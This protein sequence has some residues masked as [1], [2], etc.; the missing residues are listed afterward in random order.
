MKI[1]TKIDLASPAAE[2]IA[3]LSDPARL[4]HVLQRLGVIV[5]PGVQGAPMQAS[6]RWR[7]A[8][9]RFSISPAN[10]SA[11]TVTVR[12]TAVPA[13]AILSVTV[14]DRPGG[15]TAHAVTEVKAHTAKATIAVQSLRLVRGKAQ[16]RLGSLVAAVAG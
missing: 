7:G 4:Q 13:S 3:N 14:A 6:L 2:V 16:R 1:E 8:A 15:S 12:V 5:Q 10:V 9:R 11:G